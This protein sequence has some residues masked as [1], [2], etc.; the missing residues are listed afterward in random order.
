MGSVAAS[1]RLPHVR[2]G[3]VIAL[4]IAAGLGVWLA[5]RDTGSSH[6]SSTPAGPTGKHVVP[7]SYS[8]LQTLVAALHRPIYWAGQE[9]R[10]TY[11]LTQAPNG[12]VFVRYLNPDEPIGTKKTALTIGTYSVPG[13]FNIIQTN[14]GRKGSVRVPAHGAV[15]FYSKSAPTNIYLAFPGVDYQVEVFDPSAGRARE[16]V[17]SGKIVAVQAPSGAAPTLVSPGQLSATAKKLSHPLYWAGSMPNVSY[18]LEQVGGDKSYVR[19]LPKGDAAGANVRA[20]TIGTYAVAS[21]Y[22]ATQR[23]ATA[24]D[25]VQVPVTGGGIAFFNKSAPTSVYVAFPT[26]NVQIEVYD[27]S[28]TRARQLVTSG[29]IIAVR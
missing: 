20:L 17:S 12:S 7:I 18:E 21:A 3:A 19:Y 25:A 16:L 11:E 14:A 26:Q 5:T 28:P 4:G 13:A 23:L 29:K 1:R 10:K 15:A 2:L 22:R 9:P 24:K 8:G 6:P 27:P